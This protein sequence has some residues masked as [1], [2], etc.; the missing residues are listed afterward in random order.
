[1]NKNNGV[2]VFSMMI[3][4]I[5]Y[6]LNYNL[7]ENFGLAKR[8]IMGYQNLQSGAQ[9]TWSIEPRK[10]EVAKHLIAKILNN[11]GNK[12]NKE[13]NLINIDYIK[14]E[15]LS[16]GERFFMDI[17]VQDKSLTNDTNITKRL[18]LD[19]LLLKN[20]QVQINTLNITNSNK[21]IENNEFF[22]AS[23]DSLI[24]TN[25]VLLN[26]NIISGAE[27]IK[28]EYSKNN[29]NIK[30]KGMP[31]PDRYNNWILPLGIQEQHWNNNLKNTKCSNMAFSPEPTMSYIDKN[32][33]TWLFDK[34]RGNPGFPH[35]IS[36]KT[37]Y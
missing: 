14:T 20:G 19:F 24:I 30:N 16:S 13:L 11:I 7:K 35:G 25:D 2:L 10:L 32:A 28:L 34:T 21:Q 37:G 9:P 33:Y 6:L 8:Q 3:I 18:F 27:N 4:L 17:F 36:N 23:K 29:T 22:E 31:V 15:M 12:L 1:M 26:S 5:L